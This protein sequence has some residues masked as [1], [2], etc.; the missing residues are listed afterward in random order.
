LSEI[1]ETAENERE[2]ENAHIRN[3]ELDR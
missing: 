3:R 2:K 1:D